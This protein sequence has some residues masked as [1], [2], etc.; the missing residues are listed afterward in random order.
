MAKLEALLRDLGNALGVS[1]EQDFDRG[2]EQDRAAIGGHLPPWK[3]EWLTVEVIAD[4]LDAATAV[5][6]D[7]RRLVRAACGGHLPPIEFIAPAGEAGKISH[8]EIALDEIDGVVEA[9][10][11]SRQRG[12][13]LLSALGLRLAGGATIAGFQ[14]IAFTLYRHALALG[15]PEDARPGMSIF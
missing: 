12:D 4:W 15:G 10:R 14:A 11:V 3:E 13:D 7:S 9:C 5:V 1:L 2:V 8:R 6:A